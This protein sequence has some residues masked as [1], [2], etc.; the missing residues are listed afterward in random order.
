MSVEVIDGV[1]HIHGARATRDEKEP[2]LDTFSRWLCPVCK[3][4][5]AKRGFICLNG[6]HLSRGAHSRFLAH[7]RRVTEK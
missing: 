7:M 6:C 5:L 2:L 1:P 4:N 3:A